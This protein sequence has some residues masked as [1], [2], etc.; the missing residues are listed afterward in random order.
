MK[1]RNE[2]LPPNVYLF[3][4]FYTD[5][6]LDCFVFIYISGQLRFLCHSEGHPIT[7]LPNTSPKEKTGCFIFFFC[8][9]EIL[10]AHP[11]KGKRNAW[12]L[13]RD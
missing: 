4:A 8:E 10:G 13:V 11:G 5:K 1:R 7:L 6:T 9:N 2:G 3:C 12:G